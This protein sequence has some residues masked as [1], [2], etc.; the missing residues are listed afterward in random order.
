MEKLKI[1][2]YSQDQS[3]HIILKMTPVV[4]F[5]HLFTHKTDQVTSR[6]RYTDIIL[7]KEC[8]IKIMAGNDM[9]SY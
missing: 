2:Y 6:T 3:D 4:S 8:P 1:Y 5:G 9:S 7:H